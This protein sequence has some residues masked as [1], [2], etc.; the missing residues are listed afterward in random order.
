VSCNFQSDFFDYSM[1]NFCV[2]SCAYYWFRLVGGFPVLMFF[3]IESG[4]GFTFQIFF[5]FLGMIYENN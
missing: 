2:I 5:F 3:C 1:L 4:F